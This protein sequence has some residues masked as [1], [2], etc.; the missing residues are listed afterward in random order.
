[1]AVE[2]KLPA[3]KRSDT[4]KGASRRL[5]REKLVPGI[6]YGAAKDAEMVQISAFTLA[7]IMETEAFY[8]QVIDL[9]V[10]GKKSQQVVVKDL[11]RH[12]FK[13][14]VLHIDFQRVRAG[15]KLHMHVPLHF[16][17]DDT[18]KG[19][20]AG[21]VV[22]KDAIEVAIIALPKDL[23]EYIEV[24]LAGL[25]VGEALHLSDLK[26][27][28]GVELEA[29]AHGEDTHDSDQPVVSIVQ[30][31]VSKLDVEAE[32][33]EAAKAEEQ[34]EESAE[35]PADDSEEEREKKE[36]GSE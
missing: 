5:R 17:N 9:A 33:A 32:E 14:R 22:H 24:D 18:C 30:P 3:E 21:G 1:M 6:V 15:E 25:D 8:S 27:P 10:K 26:I 31:R 7:R 11:Q 23:P 34:A 12:P 16:L 4:G 35:E 36:G 28:E 2:L 20:K 29:F 13:D 19:V